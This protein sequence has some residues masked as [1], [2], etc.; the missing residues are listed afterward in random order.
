M[1]GAKSPQA[2][3]AEEPETLPVIWS[4]PIDPGDAGGVG[5]TA[6]RVIV[7]GTLHETAEDVKARGGDLI[8]R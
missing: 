1:A 7:P 6:E 2:A 4:P 8:R 3:A 5:N